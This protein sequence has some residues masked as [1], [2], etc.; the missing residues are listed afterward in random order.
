MTATSTEIERHE[1]PG[2]QCA[3]TNAGA[4]CKEPACKHDHHISSHV[5][6]NCTPVPGQPDHFNCVHEKRKN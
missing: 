5:E 3:S 4:V 2:P 6:I 1:H